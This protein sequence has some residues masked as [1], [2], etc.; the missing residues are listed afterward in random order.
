MWVKDNSNKPYKQMRNTIR[1]TDFALNSYGLTIIYEQKGNEQCLFATP[2]EAAELLKGCG[3]IH[4]FTFRSHRLF[5]AIQI[6]E[7][8]VTRNG[9][10][11]TVPAGLNVITWDYFIRHFDIDDQVA[12]E[13][14]AYN[15]TYRKKL[16]SVFH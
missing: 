4:N 13:L 12:Q 1:V 15:E 16:Q 7:I 9:K 2:Q 11:K 14:V 5:V 3:Y 8:C 10:Y 6:T